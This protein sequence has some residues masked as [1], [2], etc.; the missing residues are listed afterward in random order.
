MSQAVW[1]EEQCLPDLSDKCTAK[2]AHPK[3]N[4]PGLTCLELGPEIY[5]NITITNRLGLDKD[6]RHVR[7]SLDSAP[8]GTKV[9][10]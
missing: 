3:S 7:R 8:W 10:Q 4:I 1:K 5:T 9:L 6:K 2:G